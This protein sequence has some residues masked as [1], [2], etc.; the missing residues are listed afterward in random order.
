MCKLNYSLD[1]QW[2]HHVYR[3]QEYFEVRF[4]IL[5]SIYEAMCE[6]RNKG[7]N[8]STEPLMFQYTGHRF[9]YIQPTVTIKR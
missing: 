1:V 7:Y 8:F 5:F 4:Y 2:L 6:E 3:C 9:K